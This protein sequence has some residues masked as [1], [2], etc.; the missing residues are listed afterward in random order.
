MQAHEI[1]KEWIDYNIEYRRDKGMLDITYRKIQQN[2]DGYKESSEPQETTIQVFSLYDLYYATFIEDNGLE[3]MR[4]DIL[5]MASNLKLLSVKIIQQAKNIP[6]DTI[7]LISI[8]DL[9]RF[10]F[11]HPTLQINNITF[12]ISKNMIIVVDHTFLRFY[13]NAVGE[14]YIFRIDDISTMHYYDAY[15]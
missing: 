7:H 12:E 4:N 9:R 8:I 2:Y 15:Q 5:S 6:R 1:A 14:S 11:K 10:E 3:F 13:D